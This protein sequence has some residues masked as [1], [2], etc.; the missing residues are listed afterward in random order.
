MAD[1]DDPE[2]MS[3]EGI[4]TLSETLNMD[5]SS[6]V[7]VLVLMWKLGAVS[8]PGCISK[9]EFINGMKSIQKTNAKGLND[10]LPMLDPGF[11]EK[12]DFRGMYIGCIGYRV[13]GLC[14]VDICAPQTIL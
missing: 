13:Y 10:Y 4:S 12:T 8:K 3:M 1:E 6:D 5:P 14:S 7:R 2:C 11:I 9:S